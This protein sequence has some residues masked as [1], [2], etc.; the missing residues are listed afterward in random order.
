M[1]VINR[2]G[3]AAIIWLAALFVRQIAGSRMS[4]SL[5][6]SHREEQM[7]RAMHIASSDLEAVSQWLRD[8]VDLELQVMEWRLNRLQRCADCGEVR[9]ESYMLRRALAR[10]R[11]AILAEAARL[12]KPSPARWERSPLL[13]GRTAEGKP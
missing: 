3:A 7:R 12:G 10:A 6:L 2:L 9:T 11:Q 4:E 8:A 13:G 5:V 1:A